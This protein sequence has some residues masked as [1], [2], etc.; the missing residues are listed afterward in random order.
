MGLCRI[1]LSF[2]VAILC[3]ISA[4]SAGR[5]EKVQVALYYESLCPY[6]AKFIVNYLSKI[7]DNGL[8]D[9]VDLDLV[10][11]GN[12]RI[13]SNGT[14]ICQHGRYECLLNTIE[15]CAIHAWPDLAEH[16]KF[17]LCVEGLVLKHKYLNWESCF[18]ET[19][20]K[21]EAV[22][23]CY[24]SGYGE[25]LELQYAAQTDALIPPHKY[26]PWVVVNGQP[27]YDDYENL[28]IYICAACKG[29]SPKACEGLT[30]LTT[31]SKEPIRVN[32][33]SHVD[34]TFESVEI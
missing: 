24:E 31:I 3:S 6:S 27:L 19:G 11:Y 22:S 20:L 29:V 1:L 30:V 12:A 10:P 16:F 17:I 18:R 13:K 7:F 21:S 5:G 33:V 26:V 9:V 15:A 34:E 28:E 25:K 4:V 32:H 8:I 2:V 23:N 14:I